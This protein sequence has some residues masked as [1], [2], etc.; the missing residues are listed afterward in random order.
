MPRAHLW[1]LVV[2]LVSIV[3]TVPVGSLLGAQPR[4]EQRDATQW[5]QRG[6]DDWYY[7]D[8]WKGRYLTGDGRTYAKE[9]N[10]P[11]AP[12][13]AFIYVWSTSQT[14]R[15]NGQPVG[16]DV[17]DG[18]IEDYDITSFLR[19]GPN[20][21]EVT[22]GGEFICEG[23]AVMPDGTE[24]H[25]A[26][27]RS[28]ATGNVQESDVRRSGPRGYAGDTHMARIVT[29]T[30]EQKAKA[31]VNSLNS[32]RRRI[33]DRDRYNF[34][35]ARDP[36]EVLT[37]GQTTAAR[38]QWERAQ[39]LLE[40]SRPAI[41]A[42]S[43]MILAGNFAQVA[44]AAQ[45]AVLKTQ[46]AQR[47]LAELM[48]G[49]DLGNTQRRDTLEV[50][51]FPGVRS[52]FSYNKSDY[53]R[54]GWVTSME[55]L[56]NDP[57]YWEADILIGGA[58]S[59][60]LAG[61]WRF[62]TDPQNQGLAQNYAAADF[63]DSQ[64][65]SIYAPTK[66]GWERFGYTDY[67]PNVRGANKPY[68]GYGWYRKTLTIPAAWAGNDLILRLGPRWNN[69]DWLAVNGQ[70]IQATSGR[71]SSADAI[72][73]PAAL[74]RFGQPNTLA[75]RVLNGDNIGGI[76]N[77]GLRLSVAG[78]EPFVQR[79]VVGRGVARQIVAQTPE[80]QVE[81]IAYSSALSPGVVVANSGRTI[82]L[83]GW[84]ARG[85]VQPTL[86]GLATA[87][88]PVA[89]EL[90]AAEVAQ[91][92]QQMTE[93]W[94]VLAANQQGA[95]VPRP[96]MLVLERRPTAAALVDDGFGGQAL[97]LT[98]AAPG[99]RVAMIRPFEQPGE[100]ADVTALVDRVRLWSRALLRYPVG[101]HEALSFTGD[102]CRVTMRYDYMEL[103]DDW[104]TQPLSLAPLPMLFSYA[105]Q[106][107]WPA[108]RAEGSISDL[109]CRAVTGFY[110]GFDCGTY[111]AAVGQTMVSYSFNRLE[112]PVHYKGAGTMGEENSIGEKM[113][114]NMRAWGFNG[115]RP[116]G[117][118]PRATEYPDGPGA[119]RIDTMLDFSAKYGL[120]CFINYGPNTQSVP[121]NRRQGFID[122][123]VAMAKHV[124]NRPVNVP[125]LNFINEPAHIR[126]GEYNQ[127][128]KDVTKAV[129]EVNDVHWLSVEFGG[130]WAQ[131]EDSDMTEPT[132]DA[133]T[134]YQF[135]FYGPH[136]DDVHRE[137]L[138]YPRYQRNE[139]RFHSYEGWEERMLSPIRFI[140]RHQAQ[141]MHGEF[142]ISFLGPDQSPRKWL[143][144]VLS[145]HEKYRMHWNWWN[146][147]GG[148]IH[149]TGLV[150]GDRINPLVETLSKYARMAPPGQ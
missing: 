50:G 96:L 59:I 54:L 139:E 115:F 2:V 18:T 108:A 65:R 97:E 25:F 83:G 16:S 127:L 141:V 120:T 112:P 125:V 87:Q 22:A 39:R 72:T 33:H 49:L 111:R 47:I 147:S 40:E 126:W 67:N 101:V 26:S 55:P 73:I 30:A 12:V 110:P 11:A 107:N 98:F 80:G 90:I 134:I 19:P 128:M 75:L 21:I 69:E 136:T 116:Q 71:G 29:V 42:A 89:R 84:R 85:Y 144:D 4:P 60:A 82:R 41:E 45:P 70:F 35:K 68:N 123:W 99:G 100:D 121:D 118:L 140:I 76:I 149:R 119:R 24:V 114:A 37:L 146:Y 106:H 148:D 122:S 132:G 86:I 8:D 32:I 10:L 13:A 5:W 48:A 28:W 95:D 36:R 124:K 46:E 145:I 61:W 117:G 133:K 93:N 138:W 27:D 103:K 17:D 142:G 15:V 131:P 7:K 56:D 53:N 63:N 135:H 91:I 150:A 129:R 3:L 23:A 57:A 77:P 94:L 113:Y 64:W 78:Q 43:A 6:Q 38:Q 104:N 20:R 51:L 79:H 88:G 105:I 74:V 81:Q 109:G 137:D 58:Q 9:I 31:L 52:Y 14:V 62:I 66:W 130:G 102:I 34:W 143:E 1:T 44:A 92:P